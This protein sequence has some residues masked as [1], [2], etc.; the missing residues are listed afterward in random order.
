MML[1][2]RYRSPFA[3]RAAISL[4]TLGIP[5]D[6]KPITAWGNLKEMRSYNPVGRVPALVLDNGE[7]LFDSNAILDY[8]DQTVGPDKALIPLTEPGRHKVMRLVVAA[9]G[10][11]EKVVHSVYEFTM[12]PPEKVHQPWIDHNLSQT[13]EAL[14]WLESLPQTPWLE[15]ARMTQADITT[16]V[17]IQFAQRPGIDGFPDA[18]PKGSFPKLESLRDRIAKLP[19]WQETMPPEEEMRFRPTIPAQG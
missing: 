6:H 2:G 13:R 18:F 3:R 9:M 16:A 8:L 7:V 17:V 19:A 5:Y 15:S 11:L 10:A 4:K 12:H 1:V 14:T